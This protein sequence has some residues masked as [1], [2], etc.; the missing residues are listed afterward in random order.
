MSIRLN[1]LGGLA[2]GVEVS[3]PPKRSAHPPAELCGMEPVQPNSR[4][5]GWSALY[6]QIATFCRETA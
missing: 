6:G 1:G 5:A 3:L 2:Y 4:C